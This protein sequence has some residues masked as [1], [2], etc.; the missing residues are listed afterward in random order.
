M[1]TP[2]ADS[3]ARASLPADAVV[4]VLQR[5][6]TT[7]EADVRGQ[8]MTGTLNGGARIRIVFTAGSQVER[9]DV[10]AFRAAAGVTVHRVV[11][12]GVG[13]A[14]GFLLTRGDGA[15]LT[16][17]PVALRQVLGV[18]R[19]WRDAGEWRP[20]A[21]PRIAG[22]RRLAAVVAYWPVLTAFRIDPS[23]AASVTRAWLSIRG[24]YV[25]LWPRGA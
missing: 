6:G 19:E 22:W 24:V 9:G 7:L 23:L 8:S 18:V 20:V 14:A 21:R 12:T 16:D 11:S 5:A 13:R 10:V 2:A 3:I 25:R 17:P 15:L 4:E 1:P